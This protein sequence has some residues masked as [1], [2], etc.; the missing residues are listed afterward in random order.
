M[1]VRS[2]R[3]TNRSKNLRN[4]AARRLWENPYNGWHAIRKEFASFWVERRAEYEFGAS[5]TSIRP[6]FWFLE[7]KIGARRLSRFRLALF[8]EKKK[9]PEILT[10]KSFLCKQIRNSQRNLMAC[11]RFFYYDL[12]KILNDDWNRWCR[13]G[14]VRRCYR[15]EDTPCKQFQA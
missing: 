8:G 13:D 11:R 7:S 6:E 15:A 3:D 2:H 1:A 10:E 4:G 9:E 5:F 14:V 12:L